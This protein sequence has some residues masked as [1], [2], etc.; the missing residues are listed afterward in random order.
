MT[1]SAAVPL[2]V[3]A[4]LTTEPGFASVAVDGA[5]LSIRTVI[6]AVVVLKPAL[7]ATIARAS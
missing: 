6:V 1:T 2:S 5:V 7:S 4:P 3:T